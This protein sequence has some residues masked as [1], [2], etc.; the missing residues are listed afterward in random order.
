MPHELE[1][2]A[3]FHRV[4]SIRFHERLVRF[5][6]R[7]FLLLVIHFLLHGLTKFQVFRLAWLTRAGARHMEELIEPETTEEPTVAIIDVDRAKP[8]LTEFPK[9]KR[10]PGESTHECRI[11]LLAIAQIDDKVPVPALDHLFYE[12]FETRAILEGSAAFHLYPDGA[13]NAADLDR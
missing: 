6:N 11:H 2:I 1:N 7:P 4:G 10:D 9:P 8:S 3:E 13:V 5:K 12:F